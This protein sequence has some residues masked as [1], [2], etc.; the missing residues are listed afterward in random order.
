MYAAEIIDK[1]LL[2]QSVDMMLFYVGYHM[3]LP[4]GGR[5]ST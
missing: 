2:S 5:V 4:S 1:I 3:L